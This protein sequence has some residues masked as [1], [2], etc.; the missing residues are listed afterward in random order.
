MVRGWR[1]IVDSELFDL[2]TGDE[3]LAVEGR[4][5]NAAGGAGRYLLT[6]PGPRTLKRRGAKYQ[7]VAHYD[8]PWQRYSEFEMI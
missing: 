4:P 5:V 2:S 8:I 1:S 6:W 3:L 7:K